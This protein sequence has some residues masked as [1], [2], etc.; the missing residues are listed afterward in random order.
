MVHL[1]SRD[2]KFWGKIRELKTVMSVALTNVMEL[3]LRNVARRT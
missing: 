3:E 2:V 1:T